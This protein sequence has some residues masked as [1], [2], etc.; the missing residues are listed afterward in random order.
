MTP[1]NCSTCDIDQN[2][3]SVECLRIALVRAILYQVHPISAMC[4]QCLLQCCIG[5]VDNRAVL[6]GGIMINYSA[7]SDN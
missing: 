3:V 1:I 5:D 6:H 7:S 2:A 4:W